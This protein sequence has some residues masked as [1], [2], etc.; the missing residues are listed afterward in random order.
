MTIEMTTLPTEESVQN[1]YFDDFYELLRELVFQ[2]SRSGSQSLEDWFNQLQ[3]E[4]EG[5]LHAF[6]SECQ[7]ACEAAKYP[8]VVPDDAI[9]TFK[10]PH[11]GELA[12][13]RCWQ[14]TEQAYDLMLRDG[15][16][17]RV[18]VP[19]LELEDTTYLCRACDQEIATSEG[20][21][22]DIIQASTATDV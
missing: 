22:L 4:A 12:G 13:I 6:E 15:Q 18:R 21:I 9:S 17:V 3:N 2:S 1:K 19:A 11:C 8:F 16:V 5:V 14:E 20:E 7:V 10:C